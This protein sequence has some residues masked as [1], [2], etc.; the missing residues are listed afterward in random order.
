MA[1][2]E[3]HPEN[4]D[5]VARALAEDGMVAVNFGVTGRY[6]GS[7]IYAD[8]TSECVTA[9]SAMSAEAGKDSREVRSLPQVAR[10]VTPLPNTAVR[11]RYRRACSFLTLSR[12]W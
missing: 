8:A 12:R 1:A 11:C 7:T 9:K 4:F 5:K 10:R 2:S 3:D 6:P